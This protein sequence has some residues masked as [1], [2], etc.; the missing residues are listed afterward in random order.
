MILPERNRKDLVDVPAE[1][2][3]EL[4]FRFAKRVDDVL[5]IALDGRG[6]S[7]PRSKTKSGRK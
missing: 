3:K 7:S 6:G 2:R 4:E 1:A 5:A